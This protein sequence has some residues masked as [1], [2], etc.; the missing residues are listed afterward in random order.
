MITDNHSHRHK[1]NHKHSHGHRHSLLHRNKSEGNNRLLSMSRT[2]MTS[3]YATHPQIAL[4]LLVTPP[5]SP[6]PHHAPT[7]PLLS[8]P[9]ILD[10]YP[11]LPLFHPSESD[12]VVL[13]SPQ[14]HRLTLTPLFTHPPFYP[15]THPLSN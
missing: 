2:G 13:S 11:S 5:L 7:R 14:F 3:R 12:C 10:L 6:P 4:K 9:F 1:H 8:P 15:L